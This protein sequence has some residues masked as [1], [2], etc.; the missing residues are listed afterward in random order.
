VEIECFS[1]ILSTVAIAKELHDINRFD[2]VREQFFDTLCHDSIYENMLG[3]IEKVF[4]EYHSNYDDGDELD[5]MVFSDDVIS[6]YFVHAWEYG[7]LNKVPPAA[8]PYIADA[9]REVK[10]RLNFTYNLNWNLLAYTKSKRAA[11]K[12]KLIVYTYTCEFYEYDHLAYGLIQLYKW[13]S[14]KCK[15]LMNK[16]ENEVMA[17]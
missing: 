17:A 5:C 14:D 6:E 13:F 12:S 16:G 9:E 1:E 4:S 7:R 8:N 3:A 2:I 15:A 10:R 11:K